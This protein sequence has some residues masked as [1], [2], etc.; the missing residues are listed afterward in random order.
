MRNPFEEAAQAS[1][2]SFGIY[3]EERQK[4]KRKKEQIADR[5]ARKRNLCQNQDLKTIRNSNLHVRIEK[6]SDTS[7][8]ASQEEIKDQPSQRLPYSQIE[9]A[10]DDSVFTVSQSNSSADDIEE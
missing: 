8:S 7:A 2:L 4:L 6:L 5:I 3:L 10:V 1:N 9:R